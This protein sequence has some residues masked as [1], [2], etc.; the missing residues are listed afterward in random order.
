MDRYHHLLRGGYLVQEICGSS[1]LS[2]GG[3]TGISLLHQAA[4]SDDD[5]DPIQFVNQT[6]FNLTSHPEGQDHELNGVDGVDITMYGELN[7]IAEPQKVRT[8][9]VPTCVLLTEQ[10]CSRASQNSFP[11]ARSPGFC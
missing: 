5:N 3:F 11:C 8:P 2:G 10:L 1:R 6:G 4:D 7:L 9:A